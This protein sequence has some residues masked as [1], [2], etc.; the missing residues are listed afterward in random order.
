MTL[1]GPIDLLGVVGREDDTQDYEEI[2][3]VMTFIEV[4]GIHLQVQD[5]GSALLP[6]KM[7]KSGVFRYDYVSAHLPQES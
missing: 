2:V 1:Y 4:E 5:V 3:P 7:D 6:L